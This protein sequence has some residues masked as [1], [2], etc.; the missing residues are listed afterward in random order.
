VRIQFTATSTATIAAA[1][2]PFGAGDPIQLNGTSTNPRCLNLDINRNRNVHT[3]IR[4]RT[5]HP[6]KRVQQMQQQ[7]L[8]LWI[9]S[10]PVIMVDV[11]LQE[12]QLTS[13]FYSCS[14]RSFTYKLVV[15]MFQCTYGWINFCC[16]DHKL[17]MDMGRSHGRSLPRK[18]THTRATY[19]PSCYVDLGPLK[20]VVLI[21]L[22]K[23]ECTINRLILINY[24]CLNSGTTS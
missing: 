5:I 16:S 13:I 24:G 19:I 6:I 17:D 22:F 4:Q 9:Y 1:N 14:Y 8:L 21:L 20:M 2:I 15:L 23:C 3:K 7:V 12:I 10:N 11:S 18:P